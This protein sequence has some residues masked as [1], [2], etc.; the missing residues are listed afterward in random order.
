MNILNRITT[1]LSVVIFAACCAAFV[2]FGVSGTGWKALTIPTGSMRPGMPPGSL[3]LVH[4]VPDSSLKIGNVITFAN[5]LHP[6]TTVSHRIIKQYLIDGKIPGI[7]TKGDANSIPDT[8]IAAGSVIGKV[9]WHVPYVGAWLLWAKT[10]TGLS[11]LVYFPAVLIIVEE[12]LRLN[13]YYKSIRPYRLFG[14]KFEPKEGPN[15]WSR[16]LAS[17]AA[18]TILVMLI[19]G[20]AA[21]VVHAL[22]TSNTVKLTQNKISV[23]SA[24]KGGGE[25]SGGTNNTT[26]VVNNTTTQNA[27]TGDATASGNTNGGSATSGNASNSNTTDITVTVTNCQ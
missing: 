10:W 21:P 2:L 13:K 24:N 22:L 17:G 6:S 20:I 5:Q 14:Y 3:A 4:R 26:T 1:V 16:R 25:C 27:S 8:P 12:T 7:V 19:S 15:R 23:T 11:V 18:M 9:M